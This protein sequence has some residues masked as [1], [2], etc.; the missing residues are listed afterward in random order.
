MP[1]I[2]T[3]CWYVSYAL[4]M[5]LF[6]GGIF[7]L[8]RKKHPREE[9]FIKATLFEFC[10]AWILYLP[11]E[12]FNDVPESLPSLKMAE[13]IF[14]AFLRTFNIYLGNDYS[15]IEF[16]GHP[17]FSSLYATLITVVNI[18]MLFF[19][20]G[21][22]VKFLEGPVQLMRMSLSKR[23][24]A[25]V[26]PVCNSKTLA[27]AESIKDPRTNIIFAYGDRE[28][29]QTE[30]QRINDIGGVYVSGS[31][32]GILDRIG[33]RSKG[34]EIFLFGDSEVSNLSEL[35]KI[36]DKV[37]AGVKA[38]VRIFVELSD[39]PWDLYDSFLDKHNTPAGEKLIINFV[40]TEESFAYNDLLKY[41]IFENAIQTDEKWKDIK[42]LI[43]GM[44]ERNLEMLKAVLHL[45]QMP[46]Y[47]LTVM[48]LDE[49]DG[50]KRLMAK[51]PEVYDE[52]KTEGDAIYHLIYK[53]NVDMEVLEAVGNEYPD[54][55]FAFVN[56]GND[57]KNTGIAVRLNEMC[58]RK[59]RK[60]GYRI[61]VNIE[62]QKICRSWD[63]DITER[64]DF[65]GDIKTI[66]AHD[67]I[68]MSDIEKGAIAI[69]EV[70]YPE[71]TDRYRS[72]VSY[73]NNEY[74]RHSVYART[75]SFKH[76]VKIIHDMYDPG[77]ELKGTEKEF[78][79]YRVT[80]TNRIWKIYEHM[81]W[82]MYTRTRGFVLADKALLDEDG[83]V[84]KKTRSA[85]RVHHDL[86][87][88]S[89][90]PKE[91]QDKD[92]LELTPEIVKILRDI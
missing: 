78:D 59:G 34:I 66:Y 56:A 26:F 20:A 49:S 52:C 83:R 91:D 51:L 61:Q 70:R 6:L 10:A 24:P 77:D 47:R 28:P 38:P 14:T 46:G 40:R 81:R 76:K 68:T 11:E 5:I 44:N 41:S 37:G 71:G 65:V 3:I 54:F 79:I 2:Q 9:D 72:W 31:V 22:I 45:G 43:V 86:I 89:K 18:V 4:G 84:D 32:A 13:S 36:C 16:A 60:A 48:V 25:Y 63:S 88:Y 58:L 30:K 69:H 8:L 15:R 90:L 27:I 55:T 85:A 82:N 75:L 62:D 39:T 64:M 74:N 17:V 35:E 73:C 50:R 23:R 1:D 21:L 87:H 67:F 12:I 33:R 19:V 92:A 7:Y 29:V 80:K 53:E 57:L 42:V